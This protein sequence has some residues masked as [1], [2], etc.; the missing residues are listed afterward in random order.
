MSAY[1]FCPNDTLYHFDRKLY[2][3]DKNS[4]YPERAIKNTF[5]VGEPSVLIGAGLNG[6]VLNARGCVDASGLPL[7]GLAQ[8]NG[9][10][11]FA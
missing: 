10:S 9:A 5:P 2:Y 7:H 11:A 4:L 1:L 3:I 6:V 8:V